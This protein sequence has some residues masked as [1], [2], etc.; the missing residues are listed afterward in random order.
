MEC[1]VCVEKYT[2]EKRKLVTCEFCDYKACAQC[3]K[4]YI[5]STTATP[6]CMNCNNGWGRL[7]ISKKFTQSFM[8]NEFKKARENILYELEKSMFAE[9]QPHVINRKLLSENRTKIHKNDTSIRD[10][11]IRLYNF[12]VVDL[13]TKKQELEMRRELTNITLDNEYLYFEN[14]ILHNNP[15]EKTDIRE[16][17]KPCCRENCKGFLSKQWKCGLCSLY[18]CNECHEPKDEGHVCDSN[19]VETVKHLKSSEYKPCPACGASIFKISGCSQMYCTNPP[20]RKVFDWGTGKIV[21]GR[22]HNPHYYEYM[23]TRGTLDR[24]IGDIQCGG[25]VNGRELFRKLLK[26]KLSP[27][28]KRILEEFHRILI[29]F[30]DTILNINPEVDVFL[31][32]LDD[33]VMYMI[34]YIS[35][36]DFKGLIQRKDKA[37]QKKQEIAMVSATFFQIMTDIYNRF[38]SDENIDILT[39]LNEACVY[40]NSLWSDIGRAYGGVIPCASVTEMT[41]KNTRVY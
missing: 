17:I 10:L 33:R 35:E 30:Q 5:L 39:E 12:F 31:M 9:T 22:I 7:S 26:Y 28:E 36:S 14:S 24:E 8:N 2:R 29:E 41:I 15:I 21:T 32:N 18:T 4:Q 6:H 38:M 11:K 13:D 3:V 40:S 20:C 27:Q 34:G 1:S 19:N 37:K 23:R 25:L 16:F